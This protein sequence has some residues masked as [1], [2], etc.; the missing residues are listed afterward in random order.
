MEKGM[1]ISSGLVTDVRVR[2]ENRE[3]DHGKLDRRR[4]DDEPL[5]STEPLFSTD[6]YRRAIAPFKP[7]DLRD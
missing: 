3:R 5:C 4:V 7:H 1:S 6:K 2:E